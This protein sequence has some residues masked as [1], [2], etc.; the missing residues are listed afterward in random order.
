VFPQAVV[1]IKLMF[2]IVCGLWWSLS[3]S[4][5]EGQWVQ[6]EFKKRALL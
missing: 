6:K 5:M 1:F 4:L 3:L 2:Y